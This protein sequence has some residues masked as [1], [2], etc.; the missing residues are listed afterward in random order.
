MVHGLD[1]KAEMEKAAGHRF[2]P[3]FH[4]AHCISNN[5]CACTLCLIRRLE[6][7]RDPASGRARDTRNSSIRFL[8][9]KVQE[10]H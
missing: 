5:A 1:L 4:P 6:R 7:L 2:I 8:R 10:G 9:H 3:F